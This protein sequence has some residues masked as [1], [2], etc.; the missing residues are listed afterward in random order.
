MARGTR[1][2][3]ETLKVQNFALAIILTVSKSP[4]IFSK[5]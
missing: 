2:L 5:D 3:T 1:S 4:V